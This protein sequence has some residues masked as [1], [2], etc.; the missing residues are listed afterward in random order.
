MRLN[1]IL[2]VSKEPVAFSYP[3]RL[4]GVLHR[5]LGQNDLHD[6]LSLYSFS[7]L[8][9]RYSQ[10]ANGKLHFPRGATWRITLYDD[11][12]TRALLRGIMRDPYVF[13]GM[14]VREAQE[15]EP[16]AFGESHRF[17]IDGSCVLARRKREDGSQA[18]LQFDQPEAD[19][20]LTKVLR[21]KLH[22]AGFEGVHLD[23]TVAF[24]RT[25]ANART[26][27]VSLRGIQ[28]KGSVCP[29]IVTGT[30]EVLRFVWSVGVGHLTGSGFGAV[31]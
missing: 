2:S 1:L 10:H 24:D 27:L 30:P 18:Y 26:K 5:W 3:L 21:W 8:T 29:V 12:A 6:G 7:W 20:V 25:Y 19:E 15:Q 14:R 28:H 22:Q 9:S 11:E 23:A 13:A 16:P 4:T 31:R 17:L